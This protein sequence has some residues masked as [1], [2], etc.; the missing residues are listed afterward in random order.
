MHRVV[1]DITVGGVQRGA[2]QGVEMRTDFAREFF[3]ETVVVIAESG[4]RHGA[5][6]GGLLYQRAVISNAVVARLFH[7]QLFQVIM[8]TCIRAARRQHDIY[9]TGASCGNRIFNGG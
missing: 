6:I 5:T 1:A 3:Q 9:A 2:V 4:L 8:N 7:V